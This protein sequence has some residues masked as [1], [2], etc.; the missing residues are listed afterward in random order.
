ME[1]RLI[2][3]FVFILLLAIA[4]I[5]QKSF[6]F[7]CDASTA[8]PKP[9]SYSRVQ[10]VWWTFIILASI[11]ATILA[12]AQIPKLDESTLI[13][14]GIGS[15]TTIAAKTID[16]SDDANQTPTSP[17]LSKNEPSQGFWLDILSDKSGV[18]IH[19]FQAMV[20]NLVFGAWFIYQTV[21][22]LKGIGSNTPMDAINKIIPPIETSNLVLLGISAGTYAA[23]K[24][25]ENK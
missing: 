21:L 22:H 2:Y 14:L 25:T 4:I 18:S 8:T 11:I 6:C 9:Y 10:L 13:L 7:I 19:R 1:A 20:F 17:V 16:I 12:S 24:T 3:L 5:L 23:L 15:I